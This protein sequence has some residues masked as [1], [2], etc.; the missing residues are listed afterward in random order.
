MLTDA[1]L[2]QLFADERME[3]LRADAA[4]DPAARTSKRRPLRSWV[5]RALETGR[6]R[7]AAGTAPSP[8]HTTP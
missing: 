8:S 7:R 5:A 2:L 6:S 4:P 3:R 1:Y